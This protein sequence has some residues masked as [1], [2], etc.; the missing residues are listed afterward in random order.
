[1]NYPTPFIVVGGKQLTDTDE[2]DE[3]LRLEVALFAALRRLAKASG[4]APKGLDR[5]GYWVLAK[6]ASLAPI[7]LSD[8]AIALELDPSTVSRHIKTLWHAGFVGR[9]SDPGDRRAA[10]LTPTEAGHQALEA[11]RSLRLQALADSMAGWPEADRSLLVGLLERL[12]T[13]GE[14]IDAGSRRSL[15]AS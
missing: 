11:S 7:R 4:E 3:E 2:V 15:V 14:S 8:L 9:E 13:D 6:L 5:G 12:V 1:V 10:L